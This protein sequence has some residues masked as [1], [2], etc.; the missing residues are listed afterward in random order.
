M[1]EQLDEDDVD[2][3]ADEALPP[4]PAPLPITPPPRSAPPPFN[5]L[6]LHNGPSLQNRHSPI[7]L[8][9]INYPT[10]FCQIMYPMLFGR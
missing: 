8:L 6:Q 3:E 10:S 2:D 5:I 7:Y 9:F 4:T 1:V